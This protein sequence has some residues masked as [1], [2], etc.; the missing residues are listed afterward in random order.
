MYKLLETEEILIK[1]FIS[2]IS[3]NTQSDYSSKSYPSTESQVYFA[4]MLANECVM[5]GLDNVIVDKNS[6][7]TAEIPANTEKKLPTIGFIA[8]MDTSPDYSGQNIKPKIIENYDGKD[9][10]LSNGITIETKEFPCLKNYI[11]EKIITA[12]GTTLLG[13]DDKAGIAEI[14]TAMYVLI[15]NPEIEHGKIK[16]T[17]TPDEEIGCGVNYFDVEKF[18]C[19]FA[20]TID[21]GELGEL[22]Y[23]TFNA[24]RAVINFNGRS[25]HPGSAKDTMIN[26][27][28]LATELNAM[29]PKEEIPEK[30][31]ERQ[32]FYHLLSIEG[33]VS[34]SKMEYII[35]DF[36][37]ENFERRKDYLVK[38]TEDINRNYKKPV[39][40]L[41][42]HDEY[43]N[44]A[45][46]LNDYPDIIKMAEKA[47]IKADI[48]P[49]IVPV[50]GG[51]DGSRLSFLGLPC[52]NIF[53]GGHNFH[54]PYEFVVVNSMV[55]AVEVIVNI[56]LLNGSYNFN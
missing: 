24:A 55:K 39:A 10:I 13:A 25:V 18:D 30:T 21:G 8:H 53:A 51:T 23:E 28:L 52:P 7:V 16:I 22:S 47:M 41:I 4:E 38:C 48:Q 37:R 46:V 6:Y 50:R 32:G 29:L 20:Y 42:L 33:D 40:E 45:E 54:G 31:E 9:I 34:F 35:R 43:Y 1:R 56:V 26:S 27:L 17:F 12:D 11:G 14:L 15:N 36:D 19:D 3:I 5:L 2:L 44:M 49:K